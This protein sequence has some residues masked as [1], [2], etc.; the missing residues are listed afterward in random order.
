MALIGATNNHS[1]I[2]ALVVIGYSTGDQKHSISGSADQKQ[3]LDNTTKRPAMIT[4]EEEATTVDI[5]G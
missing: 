1:T 2:T 5:D 4:K 3:R